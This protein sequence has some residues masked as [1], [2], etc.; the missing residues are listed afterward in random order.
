MEELG[1]T[2][3]NMKLSIMDPVPVILFDT[4]KK[5]LFWA[6]IKEQ[7]DLMVTMKRAPEWVRGNLIMTDD[8]D[9]VIDAYRS[10]LHLF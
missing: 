3:C 5:G 10:K 4:E 2:L 7:I 1:I 6:G 9:E 8:P